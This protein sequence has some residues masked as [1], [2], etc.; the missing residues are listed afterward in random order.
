MSFSPLILCTYGDPS[1]IGP[2]ITLRAMA[3]KGAPRTLLLGCAESVRRAGY[4]VYRSAGVHD[5]GPRGV[6]SVLDRPLPAPALPGK[7]QRHGA[8]HA[9]ECLQ[10]AA[11]LCLQAPERTALLTGPVSKSHLYAV[12][13]D[14]PGQTEYLQALTG[15]RA[16]MMLAGGTLRTVPITVHLPLKAVPEALTI[17]ETVAKAQ[18]TVAA[19]RRDFGIARPRLACAALNPHAGEDGALGREEI[20]TLAPACARL[21]A[22]GIDI[23]DPLPADTLFHAAA[24]AGYDAVLCAYHDQA[25]I[26]L[27]TLFFNSGVNISLNLPFIRTAPDHGTAFSLAGR[28]LASPGPTIAALRTARRLLL[29]RRRSA[30]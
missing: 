21:R 16:V 7:P 15:V 18:I 11:T 1:G 28:D 3:A 23:G 13:F 10:A 24:R 2:E 4:P 26:P 30:S 19:L 12:G 29:Q 6:I 5:V 9:L 8:L 22:E 25:L 27:K 14:Y 20:D 17:A